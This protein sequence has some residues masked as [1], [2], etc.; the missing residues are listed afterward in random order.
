MNRRT[1]AWMVLIAM[2]CFGTLVAAGP[3]PVKDFQIVQMERNP[4]F[5]VSDIRKV[6]SFADFGKLATEGKYAKEIGAGLEQLEAANLNE[7]LMNFFKA[8]GAVSE[9]EL[10]QDT[11]FQWMFY[12]K[13]GRA[14]VMVNPVWVG[15]KNKPSPQNI[16]AYLFD[17]CF[18]GKRYSF[19]LPKAC[20]NLSLLKV[21]DLAP[22]AEIKVDKAGEC[23]KTG[24]SVTVEMEVS[25]DLANAK[26]TVTPDG[27]EVQNPD[28]N[29]W[30]VRFPAA[31]EYTLVGESQ[32]CDGETL[33]SGP[34]TLKVVPLTTLAMTVT[35]DCSVIKK[36]VVIETKVEGGT[37]S[38]LVVRDEKGTEVLNQKNPAA[39]VQFT[40]RIAG[41]YQVE[42]EAVGECDQ[43]KT[44]QATL[45][46]LKPLDAP[47]YLFGEAGL[48]LAKGCYSGFE[49]QRVGAGFWLIQKKLAFEVTPGLALSLTGTTPFH[50][51]AMID[52]RVALHLDRVYAALGAGYSGK[53]RDYE[54]NEGEDYGE[55]KSAFTMSTILGY[56]LNP[57][58]TWSLM[59]EFRFPVASDMKVK[60]NHAFLLGVRYT[61]QLKSKKNP[62]LAEAGK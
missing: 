16:A 33:K 7:P 30:T 41:Q 17:L 21:T 38:Q 58:R 52:G 13:N 9:G 3:K 18:Q 62:C 51:F 27:A 28:A 19:A 50:N 47:V 54:V 60:Y 2:C 23:L 49:Y 36:P 59:G 55:W 37:L 22:A 44:S 57:A 31:G 4:F 35:P 14:R 43:K 40:T 39:Q 29:H 25:T 32:R 26:L 5:K 6:A 48:M 20:M 12:R 34:V 45:R 24:D 46:F 15:R 42:A 1:V 61:W 53:V 56:Y 10:A 11:S 8:P